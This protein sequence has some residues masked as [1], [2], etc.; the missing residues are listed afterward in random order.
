MLPEQ[1]NELKNFGMREEQKVVIVMSIA[2]GLRW[3]KVGLLNKSR[4]LARPVLD[5]KKNHLLGRWKMIMVIV[6]ELV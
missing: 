1:C 5:I 6:P 3:L 4:A 2:T